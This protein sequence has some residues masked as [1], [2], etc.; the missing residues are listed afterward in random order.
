LTVTDKI[1]VE[2]LP[3]TERNSRLALGLMRKKPDKETKWSHKL[4][5]ETILDKWR[6]QTVR[7]MVT[8][9]LEKSPKNC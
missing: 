6:Q 9:Q 4:D 8:G 3:L 1:R 5:V 7:G 2:N